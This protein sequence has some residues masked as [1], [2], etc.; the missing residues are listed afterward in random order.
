MPH[1]SISHSPVFLVNSCLDLFSAPPLQ[2]AP[3]SRSYGVSLP[4]SLT[5]NRSSALVGFH[6]A[7]CVRFGT[8]DRRICL[9][10]FL[11]SLLTAAVRLPGGSRYFQVR[12]PRCASAAGLPTPLNVLFRQHAGVPL[13]RPRS[14]SAGRLRNLERISIGCAIRLPLRARLTLIRLALIRNPWPSGVV[15]R[16]TIVVTYAHICFSRG[17]TGT[18]MPD[19]TPRQCSPT[20]QALAWTRVFGTG[21]MPDYYPC[22]AARLVSCYALFE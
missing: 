21:L 15:V 13:L 8:G 14:R 12:H 3:L 7:T 10:D 16:A 4:S 18:R 5:M 1:L 17:S 19:S 20:A 22:G 11:G 9:A 2:E 6:P